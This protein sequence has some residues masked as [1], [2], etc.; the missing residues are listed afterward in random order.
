MGQRFFFELQL[1]L[2]SHRID[3]GNVAEIQCFSRPDGTQL[4][5]C[6]GGSESFKQQIA[7]GDSVT[8][9]NHYV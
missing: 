7:K 6:F 1:N 2:Y 4:N 9:E 8:V 5:F 3:A